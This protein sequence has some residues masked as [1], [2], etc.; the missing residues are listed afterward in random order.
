MIHQIQV[1]MPVKSSTETAVRVVCKS[2]DFNYFKIKQKQCAHC[3]SLS[4]RCPK[5][6]PQKQKKTRPVGD[7][8][9]F[10]SGAGKGVP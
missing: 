3:V 4:S 5:R 8:N 9:G 10:S 6:L 7:C 1:V 2:H